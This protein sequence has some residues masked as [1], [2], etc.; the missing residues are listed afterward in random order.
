M[1]EAL[2]SRLVGPSTYPLTTACSPIFYPSRSSK[3][4]P[5]VLM[6][7]F[8]L[9][10]AALL[11]RVSLK[12]H[13]H[14]PSLCL[15]RYAYRLCVFSASAQFQ[16]SPPSRTALVAPVSSMSTAPVT[17]VASS[18][19]ARI[20]P[21]AGDSVATFAPVSSH[22][23]APITPVEISSVARTAPGASNPVA[24]IAPVTSNRWAPIAHIA[25]QPVTDAASHGYFTHYPARHHLLFREAATAAS[26]DI[27][28][29]V[30]T[31]GRG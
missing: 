24:P 16:P 15:Q 6:P 25:R 26:L 20:A 8:L 28:P 29:P 2:L 14:I 9:V 1:V 11:A 30:G 12:T 4:S 13:E 18:T 31:G 21:V 22:P 10:S 27:R 19:A 5:P 7:S 17:S 3:Y 23:M